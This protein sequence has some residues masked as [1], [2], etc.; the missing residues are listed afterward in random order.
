MPFPRA[1]VAS[2][3]LAAGLVTVLS[4][5]VFARSAPQ[6]DPKFFHLGPEWLAF[7]QDAPPRPPAKVDPKDEIPLPEG[8][9]KDLTKKTCGNCHS[10]NVWVQQRHTPEK[11]SSII[12]NMISKGLEASDDDLATINDYL[13]KYLA[14]PAQRRPTSPPTLTPEAEPRM[15]RR[16]FLARAAATALTA[17]SA[18]AE[19]PGKVLSGPHFNLTIE[20]VALEIAPG[21]II[22]TVGYNGTVPG[23]L[24]RLR[25]GQPV[26]IDVTNRTAIDELVH[27]HGLTTDPLNDGAMEEGSPMVPAHGSLRYHL[28]PNPAGSRWYHTHAMAGPNLTRSTYT[29][30]YGFLLVDPRARSRTL[31]SR[32]LP[33][34]PPLGALPGP[35]DAHA[36]LGL[37]RRLGP[38]AE[39]HGGYRLRRRLRPR[40]HQRQKTWPR[41]A[42][43]ASR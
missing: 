21:L 38:E 5:P 39:G 30:Q 32:V 1:S 35:H 7:A 10:T 41:R 33:A 27:W 26:T 25:Q 23:P 13:G 17:R 37:G 4:R 3:L 11:W 6:P 31:R 16:D 42:P 2:L 15:N 43:P 18:L 40:H 28:T 20:P 29:G 14:P 12:D 19:R 22:P 8:P 34:D 36:R 24:L 9:G